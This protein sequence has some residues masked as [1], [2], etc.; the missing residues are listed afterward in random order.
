[1]TYLRRLEGQ[2]GR[3]AL[4]ADRYCVSNTCL[5]GTTGLSMGSLF[6]ERDAVPDVEIRPNAVYTLAEVCQ[7]F[8][9]SEAT[10]RRLLRQGIL[11]SGRVGRSYRFLG[12]QLL[13]ALYPATTH[14]PPPPHRPAN[15]EPAN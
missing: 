1:M 6:K 5:V 13:D 10:V 9:V 8:R 12:S 7:I 11:R 2:E 14:A 15:R 4:V 3:W